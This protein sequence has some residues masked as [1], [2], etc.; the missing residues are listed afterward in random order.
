MTTTLGYR[1]PESHRDF[2]IEV[3]QRDEERGGY[4]AMEYDTDRQ[5]SIGGVFFATDDQIK[6]HGTPSGRNAY[7]AA[8]ELVR[9]AHHLVAGESGGRRYDNSQIAFKAAIRAAYPEVDCCGIYGLWVDCM[10]SVAYCV[11][12]YKTMDRE[13]QRKFQSMGGAFSG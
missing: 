11:G 13:T 10:E 5:D 6:A 4:W 8:V 1:D 7:I 12:Q 2:V 3:G 9:E